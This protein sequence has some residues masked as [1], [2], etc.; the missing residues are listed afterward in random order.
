[1]FSLSAAYYDRFYQAKD[2]AGESRQLLELIQQHL[3]LNR[4]KLLDVA[5]GTGRHSEYLK[6]SFDIQGVDISE[7]LLALAR[8][9]N[10]ELR[11]SRGDMLDFDLGKQFDVVTCL[12]SAIGYVKTLSNLQRAVGCMARHVRQGGG[13]FIEPWFTPENWHAGSVHALCVEEPELKLVRMNTSQVDGKVSIVDFHYL[14]GTPQGVEHFT[15]LHE[16]GLFTREEMEQA[17]RQAGLE[18]FYDESGLTGRGL[19][20]GMPVNQA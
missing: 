15:E 19:Y 18:V 3:G 7:E 17:F 8:Q 14:V 5:C 13:L 10:P 16:L 9:R 20:I 12:F 4:G 1:M 11:F 2:Y 6:A